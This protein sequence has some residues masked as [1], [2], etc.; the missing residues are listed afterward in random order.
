MA[1]LATLCQV[2]LLHT[3]TIKTQPELVVNCTVVVVATV[4]G[5]PATHIQ[6]N[7]VSLELVVLV[8]VLSTTLCV[9]TLLHTH[10]TLIYIIYSTVCATFNPSVSGRVIS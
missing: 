9:V 7:T 2:P 6:S 1:V 5:P 8:V 4:S 10:N 3:D